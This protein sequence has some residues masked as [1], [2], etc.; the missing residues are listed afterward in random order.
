MNKIISVYLMIISLPLT[1]ILG[2]HT[3][4]KVW[5]DSIETVSSSILESEYISIKKEILFNGSI[6]PVAHG[7]FSYKKN[8][9]S[10][11]KIP[12]FYSYGRI[13]IGKDDLSR[14]SVYLLD[15]SRVSVKLSF[16]PLRI[17]TY[18][19][20][21]EVITSVTFDIKKKNLD[22][23]IQHASNVTSLCSFW[24]ITAIKDSYKVVNNDFSIGSY[25][26]YIPHEESKKKRIIRK[27]NR[28]FLKQ[29]YEGYAVLN[30]FR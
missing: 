22:D 14:M 16:Q 17:S 2:Q 13:I 12:F 15:T 6:I 23:L 3:Q 27:L 11:L 9:D 5:Y 30:Y 8:N 4:L 1:N 18:Q 20:N 10:I 7:F 19:K 21:N 24:A 26:Y 29:Y 28:L 25:Y